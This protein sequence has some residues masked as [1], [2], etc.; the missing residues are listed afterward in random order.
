MYA[1]PSSLEVGE[2]TE[3]PRSLCVHDET[4]GSDT[5]HGGPE[6]ER[7]H[8]QR[9]PRD[10]LSRHHRLLLAGVVRRTCEKQRHFR[11]SVCSNPLELCVTSALLVGGSR[12]LRLR[13]FV[14]FLVVR[15]H[16]VLA[17]KHA[18]SYCH[19]G[20]CATQRFA[21][22]SASSALSGALLLVVCAFHLAPTPLLSSLRM[23]NPTVTTSRPQ[24]RSSR[25]SG[26]PPRNRG[27]S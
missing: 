7:F 3:K 26:A 16:A 9:R 1:I 8:L 19:I 2:Q 24:H 21:T 17:A 11:T 15:V 23:Y 18:G 13:Y 6:R 25:P 10:A 22:V 12:G 4:T 20:V 14:V 27:S 5:S